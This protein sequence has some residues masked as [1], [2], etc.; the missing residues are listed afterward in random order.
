MKAVVFRVHLQSSLT[1]TVRAISRYLALIPAPEFPLVDSIPVSVLVRY[2]HVV[3]VF[4]VGPVL[5]DP[6]E[7][8]TALFAV[9]RVLYGRLSMAVVRAL[10]LRYDQLVALRQTELHTPV[11][12][13]QLL[14]GLVAMLTDWQQSEI[15]LNM[16][17]TVFGLVSKSL[18]MTGDCRFG[19]TVEAFLPQ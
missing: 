17:S 19:S 1:S 11:F 13:S 6:A 3:L 5:T 10:F 9:A 15:K 7:A 2:L 12:H 14:S 4:L 16:P 8:V 18:V